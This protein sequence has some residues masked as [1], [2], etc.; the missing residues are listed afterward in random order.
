[1][2]EVSF[3]GLLMKMKKKKRKEKEEE[4]TEVKSLKK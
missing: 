2:K 3:E 4:A 1:M